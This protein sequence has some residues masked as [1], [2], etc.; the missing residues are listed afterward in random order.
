MNQSTFLTPR[1]AP[2]RDTKAGGWFQRMRQNRSLLPLVVLLGLSTAALAMVLV[3]EHVEGMPTATLTPA[4]APMSAQPL[5]TAPGLKST[6]PVDTPLAQGASGAA[7]V[8]AP[9][10]V[11]AP[12][13]AHPAPVACS[14]CG[15]V[16][17]VTPIEHDR[18]TSGVGAVAGGV[19]GGVLG[20]QFGQGNGRAAMTVLGAVGG[21]YAGNMVEHRMKRST[22]YQIR[23]RLN[24]GKVR[25]LEQNSP[26][27]VG[28]PVLVEGRRLRLLG[29]A[30]GTPTS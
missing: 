4:N 27:A 7:P 21:G 13:A 18:A 30:Q 19:L 15:T 12:A 22:S 20:H 23:V 11:P 3:T 9:A 8:S 2:A 1:P 25:T 6:P 28:S 16:E 17:Q 10:S 26:L 5:V 14:Q 29:A 24:D